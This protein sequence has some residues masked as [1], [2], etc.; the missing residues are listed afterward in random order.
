MKDNEKWGTIQDMSVDINILNKR[1]HRIRYNLTI[2]FKDNSTKDYTYIELPNLNEHYFTFRLASGARAV[3]F[4]SAMN[5][6]YISE[7]E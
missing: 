1:K 4:T 2:A 7:V 3:I 5:G 6:Y